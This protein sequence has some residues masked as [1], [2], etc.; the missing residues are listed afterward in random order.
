[1]PAHLYVEHQVEPEHGEQEPCPALAS[2]LTAAV[3]RG[4]LW[5]CSS[6]S[7]T[8]PVAWSCWLRRRRASSNHNYIG[9]EHILLGLIHEGEG[10]AARALESL[11]IS[12]AI[13]RQR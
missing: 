2:A 5:P 11:G 4:M 1:M 9:T 10:V 6:A 8:G 13:V 12:L 7:P 3:W